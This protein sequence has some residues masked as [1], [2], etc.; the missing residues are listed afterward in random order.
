VL[1][2]IVH[3]V[4]S[5]G[6]PRQSS[7]RSEDSAGARR[8]GNPYQSAQALYE[9]LE[10]EPVTMHAPLIP[11]EFTLTHVAADDENFEDYYFLLNLFVKRYAEDDNFTLRVVDRKSRETLEIFSLEDERDRLLDSGVADW[12]TIDRARRRVMPTLIDKH[13]ALG[14]DRSDI[15]VT[16]GRL[17]QVFEA[18]QRDAPYVEYEIRLARM[19]GLSALATELGT[20]ET[21]NRDAL[22]SRA[23]ARGRYQLMPA[24]LRRFGIKSYTLATVNGRTIRVREELHPLL[25]MEAAFIIMRASVNTVGHEIPGL[26]AYNTGTGNIFTLY[27]L[28]LS[29]VQPDPEHATVLDAYTW[30]LTDGFPI[31]RRRSTFRRQSRSYIA[32]LYGAYRAMNHFPLD[33]SQTVRA[34]LVTLKRGAAVNLTRLLTDLTS[35]GITLDWGNAQ[36]GVYEAF[37]RLNPHLQLP[38][39]VASARIVPANGDLVLHRTSS[40]TP[41]RFFLPIG[42]A[43]AL[44][45]AGLD[46]LDEEDTR[47]FDETTFR[48]PALTGEKL[49]IDLEYDRL[50]EET[51]HFGF[52]E[53]NRSRLIKIESELRRLARESPT[54]Y[55]EAQAKIARLQMYDWRSRVFR[56]LADVV[57]QW[58]RP[59]PEF[60]QGTEE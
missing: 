27:R 5:T 38:T 1:Y 33:F 51:A 4:E 21:F 16:W 22:V 25:A 9:A 37:R 39:G 44:I 29:V 17:N 55:R 18:R 3:P 2:W 32:S 43:N 45:E 8:A 50:V 42:G 28:Y 12:D 30:A 49:P 46:I 31:V 24:H 47:V 60:R 23:G 56:R 7:A 48:D 57:L 41:V 15:A 19:F 52:T 11:S 10:M 58:H 13:E 6:Q 34:E 40:A 36:D 20:V 53:K 26:S 14:H 59:S 54:P 35:E